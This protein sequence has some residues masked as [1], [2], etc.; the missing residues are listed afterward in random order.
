MIKLILFIL[1]FI[2]QPVAAAPSI[3][4]I[5]QDRN[6]YSL[7]RHLDLLED[8]GRQL[9]IE[10]I[11]SPLHRANFS[12]SSW[13][14]PN[15]GFTSS[16]IWAR[17][18][19]ANN[20]AEAIDYFLEI[21]YPLLDHIDL[22]TPDNSGNF[23][24]TKGGDYAPFGERMISYRNI[25]FPIQLDA[26]QQKTFYLR[27]ET[28]STLNLPLSLHSPAGLV[29]KINLEQT[30]L[31]LYYGILLVMMIYNLFIYLGLRDTS[32]LYYV[33]FVFSYMLFQ[34]SLNGMAF[35]YFWPNLIWWANS[36]TPLLI[37][38][39]YIFAT[40]FART[41]LDTEKNVP[42]IDKILQN[43]I[44][45]A[46]TGSLASLVFDYAT[47][48]RLAT[49]FSLTVFI[50]IFAGFKCMVQGYH[51]ARYYFCAWSI[52]LMGVT[53]YALKSLGILP[54]T[55]LTQ[56]G[57]QIGSAWE[58]ILLSMALANRFHLTNNENK[59][60]LLSYSSRLEETHRKLEESYIKLEDF[61]AELENIV[62]ERTADLTSLNENL[63]HEVEKR[64]IAEEKAEAASRAKSQFLASMSHEIRTPMNAILGMANLAA[65]TANTPKLQ[66]YIN[67]IMESGNSLLNLI[68]DILD[69]SKIEAGRLDIERINFDL[70]ETLD[71]LADMFSRQIYQKGLELIVIVEPNVPG[72]VI[73]DPLRLR[74]VL[75]N[76]INNAI[77]FTDK[78]EIVIK[79]SEVGGNPN[80]T[81]LNFS[82]HDT[83]SGINHKQIKKL[84][85]EYV[86]A[87]SSVTRVYGGTGLGLAIS[88]QIVNLMGGDITAESI[89]GRGSTFRFTIKLSVQPT[90]RQQQFR[91]PA[92]YSDTEII[93]AEN[94]PALR[95]A[96]TK[97][98]AGFGCRIKEIT[99][100][101][102][103]D[104]SL[105][106]PAL[107]LVII[108]LDHM[109]PLVD[110][111]RIMATLQ[112]R[113]AQQQ[114]TNIIVLSAP[115]TDI[116]LKKM[117]LPQSIELLSKPIKQSELFTLLCSKITGASPEKNSSPTRST[118]PISL[119][120][121][122]RGLA[123]KKILIVEDDEVNQ[124]VSSHLL[125]NMGILVDITNNGQEAL[126]I[127][128]T[129]SYDAII[130][131]IYMPVMDG[132]D[133]TR[134]IR[135]TLSL[136]IPVIALTANA[137][138]E[139]KEK[140]MAA[141]MTDYLTKPI[142]ID[143]LCACLR[144][145]TIQ[146][147]AANE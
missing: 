11:T 117:A 28:S 100:K 8:V 40:Q 138:K 122:G 127:L 76:L 90:E 102:E 3:L 121:L 101:E 92:A 64:K 17:F 132:L 70:F 144:K 46:V 140:Y 14:T 105:S 13:E 19:L 18:T 145:W 16:A 52:S 116:S 86:Q 135:N 87:D 1:F 67:I 38:I 4:Q 85:G 114:Q 31:G 82:V 74:Q 84:F 91:L 27:C 21:K 81:L 96:I 66:Q 36:S 125:T 30:L 109:L 65:K 12:P 137:M 7:G 22:Y 50:H 133:A 113:Q 106:S 2:A 123:N 104:T 75:V 48:I 23:I 77:K 49:M 53:C 39:A 10:E 73:G 61:N 9:T 119:S 111:A 63:A 47:S 25:I 56:W 110:K 115:T 120:D 94:H 5:T 108:D 62:R 80:K 95:Q 131:D 68:N 57:M 78:G 15:F 42:T 142:D 112:L 6:E 130:M 41:I 83:G 20:Q 134:A 58:V 118:Q 59:E 60:I 141:G 35:E 32:Y 97:M 88:R 44:V 146:E 45:L 55:F 147:N 71:S 69:F 33:L 37:F 29:K 43:C 126:D 107:P 72:A 136:D 93:L 51:P 24:V 34:L 143:K 26:G 54:Y 99:G 139:D 89:E 103:L 128:K 79:V 124:Q 98:L 129:K